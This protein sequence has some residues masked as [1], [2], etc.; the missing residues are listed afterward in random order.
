[1]ARAAAA[2]CCMRAAASATCSRSASRR[3][4]RIRSSPIDRCP[5]LAPALD[6]AI[7]AAWAIAEALEPMRKPLDIQVTATDDGLD[8]DVRGSGPLTAAATD[9]A[10]ARRRAAPAR[11]ADAPRRDGRAARGADA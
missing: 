2:R 6:G 5:V 7:A 10:G 3:R 4:A 1:M 8:V 11:A 9:G